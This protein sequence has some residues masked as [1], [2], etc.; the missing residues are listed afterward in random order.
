MDVVLSGRQLRVDATRPDDAAF[1]RRA[2]EGRW[3]PETLAHFEALFGAADCFIDIGA[4]IGPITLLAASAGLKVVALEP[5]PVALARLR[6]NVALNEL[7]VDILPCAL[8]HSRD[9]L[10]LF[11]GPAGHGDSMSSLVSA[12]GARSLRRAKPAEGEPIAVEAITIAQ[13]L[14]RA[15][16][17]ARFL[18]KID[19][20]GHEYSL[21]ETLSALLGPGAVGLDLS[22][23]PRAIYNLRR[24]T[25]SEIG[26]RLYAYRQTI[27]L[28]DRFHGA[29]GFSRGKP[30]NL[31]RLAARRVILGGAGPKN[32]SV[33]LKPAG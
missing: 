12:D 29:K 7:D 5:D 19:I 3:E 23:H 18:A 31:R 32:F 14:E 1:W 24:K 9:D 17:G 26:S 6:A 21:G 4:W 27:A 2:A 8:H 28:L 20:E 10:A 15:P 25:G 22:L 16:S 13:V 11:P 33:F 30:A